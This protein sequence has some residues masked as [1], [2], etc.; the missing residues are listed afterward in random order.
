MRGRSGHDIPSAGAAGALFAVGQGDGVPVQGLPLVAAV[1]GDRARW[2]GAGRDHSMAVPGKAGAGKGERQ[3]L[4]PLR[5]RAHRS[6]LLGDGRQIIDTTVVPAPKQRNTEEEK[7]ATKDG[8]IPEAFPHGADD[9]R[10]SKKTCAGMVV[11]EFSR[12]DIAEQH[13]DFLV[14]RHL[15]HLG[16]GR[17]SSRSLGKEPRA[18]RMTAHRFLIEPH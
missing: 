16:Y 9:R 18:Q 8:R 5:C 11:K 17:T 10:A 6:G 13:L 15:L 2:Q 4:R 7:A 14:P 3:A 1:S 12:A